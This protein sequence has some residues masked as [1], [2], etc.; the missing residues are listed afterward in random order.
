M[1]CRVAK[2]FP[3]LP[4]SS[5]RLHPCPYP[6]HPHPCP[7]PFRLHPCLYR[8]HTCAVPASPPGPWLRRLAAIAAETSPPDHRDG[9]PVRRSRPRASRKSLRNR[10]STSSNTTESTPPLR[11]TATRRPRTAC[12]FS[13]AA[14][15]SRSRSVMIAKIIK[16]RAQNKI[17]RRGGVSGTNRAARAR[18]TNRDLL[19][20]AVGHQAS[21][22]RLDQFVDRFPLRFRERLLQRLA[23][24]L[25]HGRRVAVRAA[26][27]LSDHAV[28]Q[29]QRFQPVGRDAKRLGR[30]RR[31][32]RAFPQDRG[33]ALG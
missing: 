19:E 10:P 22:S 2:Q 30:V 28:H 9:G 17:P 23:Q 15:V 13:T 20:F 33:A 29:A 11:P 27:G 25:H 4:P 24:R 31:L 21:E 1:K 3:F 16:S 7:S 8:L 12:V 5:F 6:F 14:T 32:V 18:S 26:E